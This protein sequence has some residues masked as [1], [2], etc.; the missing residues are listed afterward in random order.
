MTVH[1][2]NCVVYFCVFVFVLFFILSMK[3]LSVPHQAMA[4]ILFLNE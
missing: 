1:F 2:C 4:V 3:I